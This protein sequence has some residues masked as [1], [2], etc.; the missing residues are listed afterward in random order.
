MS[1]RVRFA[2]QTTPGGHRADEIASLLQ[3]A[4]R[5]GEERLALYAVRELD[6][7]GW[8]G[9]AWRRLRVVASED[10][11]LAST[12]TVL[13]V[14][15]LFENWTAERKVKAN[16]LAASLFLTHA[17][18]LLAR[19]P[20]SRLVDD[21]LTA[22]YQ[23]PRPPLELPDWVADL[24]TRRGRALGRGLDH[25]YEHGAALANEAE[26]DNPYAAEA[27]AALDEKR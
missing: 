20:K 14:R 8:P 21:A 5:R 6:L 16:P 22:I 17:T 23:G 25:F 27:R 11:G 7:G 13:A 4:I 2:D 18:I 10:V 3:K 19:A 26:V 9:Y 15:A 1:E 12:E 24:H